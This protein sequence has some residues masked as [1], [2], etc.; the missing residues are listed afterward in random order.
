MKCFTLYIDLSELAFLTVYL[1]IKKFLL[2]KIVEHLTRGK[3]SYA[4][5]CF[6]DL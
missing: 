6:I 3:V 1:V 2:L 5:T 4:Y